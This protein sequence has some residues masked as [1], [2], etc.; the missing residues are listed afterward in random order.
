V[1]TQLK[2]IQPSTN[3]ILNLLRQQQFQRT[4]NNILL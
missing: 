2:T 4:K 1:Y 3:H